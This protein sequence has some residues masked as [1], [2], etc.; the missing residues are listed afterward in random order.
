MARSYL[1]KKL[2][3]KRWRCGS[4]SSVLAQQ[5]QDPEFNPQ[6]CKKN[7]REIVLLTVII[8]IGLI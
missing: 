3:A 1:K 7:I 8:S 6:Y 5:V 2:K 4:N